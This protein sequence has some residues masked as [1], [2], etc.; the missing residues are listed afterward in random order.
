MSIGGPS[1][2][3]LGGSG[4]LITYPNYLVAPKFTELKVARHVLVVRGY[5][6]W[7]Y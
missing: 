1:K 2:S 5:P 4:A 6:G 7:L 3:H